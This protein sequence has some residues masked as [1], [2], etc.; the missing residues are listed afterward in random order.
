MLYSLKKLVLHYVFKYILTSSHVT[1]GV[2]SNIALKRLPIVTASESCFLGKVSADGHRLVN[3]FAFD[4]EDR[5]LAKWERC[6]TR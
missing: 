3:S 5:Q 1:N 2:D 6:D 4:L